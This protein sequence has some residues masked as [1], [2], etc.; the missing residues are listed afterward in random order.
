MSLAF[1]NFFWGWENNFFSFWQLFA[2]FG[3]LLSPRSIIDETYR[4]GARWLNFGNLQVENPEAGAEGRIW[5][6]YIARD[7]GPLARPWVSEHL[8]FGGDGAR[9]QGHQKSAQQLLPPKKSQNTVC[10]H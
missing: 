1:A 8:H 3:K 9:P 10:F 4:S 2:V 6:I 7:L 5:V